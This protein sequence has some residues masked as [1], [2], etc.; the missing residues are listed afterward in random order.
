MHA[1]GRLAVRRRWWVV[2]AWIAF[3]LGSQALAAAGGGADYHDVF[4]LPHTE[5]QVVLDLLKANGL[6]SRAGQSGTVVA[7]ARSGRLDPTAP[8]AGL[9]ETA[10]GVCRP[11]WHVAIISSPWGSFQCAGGVA[12][13]APQGAA[14]TAHNPLLS[15]DDRV[16]IVTVGWQYGQNSIDNF[17]GVHDA[18]ARLG[19]ASVAYEFTGQAFD[20]LATAP[21]GV[22]PELFGFLA[23]LV[24]LAVVFRTFGGAMLPLLSAAAALGSGSALIA[25]LSHAMNVATFAPQLSQL[26]VIGVGVDY[27][28]FI[29]TRHRRNLMRGMS[30]EDSVANALDTSGRA[31]LFAGATV[32]IAILGLCALGVSFLYGVAVGTSIAV[33]LTMV[34]SLT[35][36]PAVLGFLGLNVLPRRVRRAIRAGTYVPATRPTRWTQ[37]SEFVA[38]RGL[39]LSIGAAAVIV[40][41]AVPFFSMR[42][43]HADESSDPTDST[44]RRGYDLIAQAPG[45]GPGYNSTLELV[46]AGPG[47]TD[48]A[49]LR[50]VA[51]RLA[52]VRDVNPTSVRPTPVGAHLTLVTFKSTTTPQDPATTRLVRSLRAE[53]VPTLESGTANR[54]YVFGQTA[55]FVD[56]A[57]ILASKIPLFFL[58]II[59]LSFLLL[60]LAFRSLVLPLTAAAMNLFAAG[61]SFG[62]VVAIFQWGWFADV[63]GIGGGGPIDPFLPVLFFAILFGLSMDYQVFL[64]SRMHEEWVH[65]GDNARSVQVGQAETGGIITAAAVIMIAVFGGFVLGDAR[66]IKLLGLGLGGAIFIDAF[67]LRTVLV[68]AVMHRLGRANWWFPAWLD[69]ITP[70]VSVEPAEES[71]LSAPVAVNDPPDHSHTSGQERLGDV[72]GR[73]R[74]PSPGRPR[75]GRRPR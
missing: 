37:W 49:Y 51:A 23:A 26:M 38:R 75:R 21:H 61:A 53:V 59:G 27:A 28:L 13:A 64:V 62:V 50:S 34:A 1:L 71:D 32:C 65:T 55:I 20:Q 57:K 17:A 42:L 16:G 19:S 18:F 40:V 52:A 35:L 33:A 15:T 69:R 60:V 22:P 9:A 8:P 48:P 2:G 3:I 29:V 63:L 36:L 4:T 44:T 56:F 58:A 74:G 30:V 70:H 66:V 12:V 6:G 24:I 25:L 39:L 7:H 72:R 45:F 5:S 14:A 54:V 41:L 11:A 31:V 46:V 73:N 43:G 67:I 10:R 47:A 68:P